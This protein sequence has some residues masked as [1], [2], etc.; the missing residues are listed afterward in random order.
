M[1]DPD[2]ARRAARSPSTASTSSRGRSELRHPILIL[3]SDDDGFVPSDASHDLVE[4][5]PDLVDLKVFEV[6]RHT[7]LWNY[8]QERWSDSI[9]SWVE[10]LDLSPAPAAEG[11]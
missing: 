8:D 4:A 7:K 6:A 2:H 11:S 5:R 1:G 10:G 9:R 3:H